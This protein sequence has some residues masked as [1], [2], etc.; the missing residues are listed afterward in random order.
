M[1][2]TKLYIT[3][4]LAN[5]NFHFDRKSTLYLNGEDFENEIQQIEGDVAIIYIS[6]IINTYHDNVYKTFVRTG[7]QSQ[8]KIIQNLS[9]D[10]KR[11]IDCACSN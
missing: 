9:T 4:K 1:K 8:S 5:L 7:T 2:I 3:N 11:L 10:K 6:L